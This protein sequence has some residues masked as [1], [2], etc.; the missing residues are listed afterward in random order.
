MNLD[1][2]R[3]TTTAPSAEAIFDAETTYDNSGRQ[4]PQLLHRVMAEA[5]KR[6][7]LLT[8]EGIPVDIRVM[9]YKYILIAD[10]DTSLR[11]ASEMRTQIGPSNARLA[12]PMELWHM[13][14]TPDWPYGNRF[15]FIDGKSAGPVNSAPQFTL[16]QNTA[17]LCVSRKINQE[18]TDILCANNNFHYS[19]MRSLPG[20]TIDLLRNVSWPVPFS[21]M[22]LYFMKSLS[23]DYCN[24]HYDHWTDAAVND[25]DNCIARNI[26]HIDEAC[27]SLKTFSLYIFSRPPL[28][29]HFHGP[30]STGQAALALSRLRKRLDWFNLV[31]TLLESIA[32][33]RQTIAPGAIWQVCSLGRRGLP[34]VTISKWQIKGV[35]SRG[36]TIRVLTLDCKRALKDKEAVDRDSDPKDTQNGGSQADADQS[37]GDEMYNGSVFGSGCGKRDE[38]R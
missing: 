12:L 23:L 7:S 11:S 17:I 30:L 18:A 8:F 20:G 33:F 26:A 29:P 19:C 35:R 32:V 36:D 2:N 1:I 9:I 6:P 22:Q 21:G 16:L 37:G 4:T 10:A 3:E 13:I 5:V 31:S 38:V 27:P 14:C 28:A 15:G 25:I 34:K 24:S